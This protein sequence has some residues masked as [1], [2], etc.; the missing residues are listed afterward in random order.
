[1]TEEE[2]FWCK[3]DKRGEDDC[4]NWI[5]SKRNN[6]GLF[7]YKGT[8]ISAHRFM[9]EMEIDVIPENMCVLHICDNSL[10]VN[11]KHLRLGTQQDNIKDMVNKHRQA[12]G[13]NV[14]KSKLTE[15]DVR[16]IRNLYKLG[17]DQGYIAGMFGGNQGWISN[18]ITKRIWKDVK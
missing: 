4:W 9:Y 13:I 15:D 3:I 12:T 1:M 11:P 17:F 18:I 7:W 10:C 6:Y 14:F 2:R 8:N 16:Y 5:G